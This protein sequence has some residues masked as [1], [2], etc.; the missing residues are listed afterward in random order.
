MTVAEGF[1]ECQVVVNGEEI[2]P[3]EQDE[4]GTFLYRIADVSEDLMVEVTAEEM[5]LS[6][7]SNV[8]EAEADG[9]TFRLESERFADGNYTLEVGTEPYTNSRT[10]EDY[11]QGLETKSRSEF[12]KDGI[13]GEIEIKTLG[14]YTF[15]ITDGS[16]EYVS[17][18]DEPVKI[19]VDGLRLKDM[20]P[21]NYQVFAYGIANYIECDST[22]VEVTED[23][24]TFCAP[25]P[26]TNGLSY[27]LN[28]FSKRLS[29]SWTFDDMIVYG[30]TKR[31]TDA[32][33]VPDVDYESDLGQ[34]SF[35][36]ESRY[37]D[38][39]AEFEVENNISETAQNTKITVVIPKDYNGEKF[40]FSAAD[41][42]NDAFAWKTGNGYQPSDAVE[43]ELTIRNDS[44]Y[45]FA[46]VPESFGFEVMQ[47]AG[48]QTSPMYINGVFNP[49]NEHP[50]RIINGAIYKLVGKDITPT[51]EVVDGALRG[52]GYE[53]L[54]DLYKY[55]VDYYNVYHND[56]EPVNSLAQIPLKEI[57]EVIL[58]EGDATSGG[59]VR[60]TDEIM[61]QFLTA[62]FYNYYFEILPGS[63]EG[64][65]RNY[66]LAS[67][68]RQE[69][70][71]FEGAANACFEKV[72]AGETSKPLT[73]TTKIHGDANNA[74]ADYRFGF[75]F[76]AEFKASDPGEI[77]FTGT[78]VLSGREFT[79]EDTYTFILNQ[80]G[81]E[82][83]RVTVKPAENPNFELKDEEI[84]AKETGNKV[85]YTITEEGAGTTVDNVTY[86]STVYTG[87]Y[88]IQ[89]NEEEWKM[90]AVFESGDKLDAGVT[91]TNVYNASVDP[92]PDPDPNPDPKPENPGNGGGSN[93]GGGGTVTPVNPVDPVIIEPEEVPLAQLPEEPIIIEDGEV[94]LAGL[95]KT[96]EAR[97]LLLEGMGMIA[98]GALIVLTMLDKKRKKEN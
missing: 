63:Y 67:Y 79:A 88:N 93:G 76:G 80:D 36:T 75:N 61:S 81:E 32:D 70:D 29:A 37:H 16:G 59:H 42:I 53:G 87:T 69:N 39:G 96:G 31:M 60:E 82:I 52:K 24:I 56:G 14:Y 90:E 47:D 64:D 38:S 58:N 2:E 8:I 27:K 49:A 6:A 77:T 18:I 28:N 94:P 11:I 1:G 91:F 55:Y 19:S 7:S 74:Y 68:A 71:A 43:C 65:E 66:N 54:S 17:R 23:G 73:F 84:T 95:P 4:Y 92:T 5:L 35:P 33:L 40:T 72:K 34:L 86:D 12:K 22:P 62:V 51:D 97:N 78:K 15:R 10:K 25:A 45:D 50:V 48:L 21:E 57:Q 89:V 3:A 44:S 83:D 20:E 98:A 30:I 85:V 46:Y 41:I 9:L 13:D 26:K